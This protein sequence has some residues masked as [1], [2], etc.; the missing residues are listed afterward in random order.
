MGRIIEDILLPYGR[1]RDSIELPFTDEFRVL[2]FSFRISHI[3]SI[4]VV[5]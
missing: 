1:P 2:E 5:I 4:I 3:N